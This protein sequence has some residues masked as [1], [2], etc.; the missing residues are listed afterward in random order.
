METNTQTETVEIKSNNSGGLT[1][2]NLCVLAH[3]SA[4]AAMIIPVVGAIGGPLAVYLLSTDKPE[5][6]KHAK[7]ALNFNITFT[8]VMF[9]AML[10]FII[11]IGAVLVPVVGLIWLILVIIAAIKASE[12]QLYK[13]PLTF[14]FIK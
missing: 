2:N 10:S 8:I 6:Q 9:L 3:L 11:L 13:Y 5:V 12:G 4:L 14:E 1:D 7:A